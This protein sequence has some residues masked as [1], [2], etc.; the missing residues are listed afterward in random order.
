MKLSGK[1]G[2]GPGRKALTGT[3]SPLRSLHT[4]NARVYTACSASTSLG[5]QAGGEFGKPSCRMG[6]IPQQR[7]RGGSRAGTGPGNAQNS[8]SACA[9]GERRGPSISKR[10]PSAGTYGRSEAKPPGR[11][12]ARWIPAARPAREAP[13]SGAPRSAALSSPV[14]RPAGPASRRAQSRPTGDRASRPGPQRTQPRRP[15]GPRPCPPGAEPRCRAPPSSPAPP[16]GPR[17]PRGSPRA[18][19]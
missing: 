9:G 2:R 14:R 19:P 6:T 1:F 4:S 12:P 16:R 15:R 8:Q 5:H 13:A 17:G 18:L 10:S 3:G 11:P 7:R